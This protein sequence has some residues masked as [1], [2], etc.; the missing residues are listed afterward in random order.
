MVCDDREFQIYQL[1]VQSAD[2]IDERRD[3][4]TRL[5]GTLCVA[6]MAASVTIGFIHGFS[7]ASAILFTTVSIV[8][9]GWKYSLK[10][11]SA[12][13][14]AKNQLLLRME[15]ELDLD[16]RFLNEEQRIW[17]SYYV[18]TLDTSIN[19]V[20]R[21]FLITGLVLALFSVV[22]EIYPIM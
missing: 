3:M 10:S 21:T 2:K 19:I 13:L 18:T 20:V 22:N 1:Q 17:K 11:L 14:S 8:T 4:T 16:T 5:Y 6:I 15:K 7:W 12:K 9:I